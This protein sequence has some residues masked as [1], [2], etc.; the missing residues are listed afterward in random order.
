MADV[1][2][3]L[4]L[5]CA[6]GAGW[7]L[8]RQSQRK[9]DSEP[10]PASYYKGLNYLL[11]ETP[12]T[13]LDDFIESL[14]VNVQTLETHLA[15]GNL[16]R[17][18]GEVERA[19]KIH[20]NLLARPSLPPQH[21]HQAHLELARDFIS[22]G[23]LDRA[24]RL[25]EG[26]LEEAPEL[27]RLALRYLMEIYQDEKEWDRAIRIATQLLPRKSLLKPVTVDRSIPVALSHFSCER[28]VRAIRGNDFH[29]ARNHLR[30]ALQYD[31]DCIRATLLSGEIEMHT[32]H[33]AQGARILRK[34]LLQNPDYIPE[35]LIPLKHCYQQMGKLDGWQQFLEQAL[36]LKPSTRVMLEL[37][38]AIRLRQ[39]EEQERAFLEN[40]LRER[41][42]LRGV[43]ELV[44]IRM[45]ADPADAN[46]AALQR[47]IT[48]LLDDKPSYLCSSC[49]F[50]GQR[51]HWLCP[52]CKEWGVMK[53]IRGPE[54]D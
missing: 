54:G 22:A 13:A 52:S 16:M 10:F 4:L 21:L 11:N 14:E 40:H 28:A 44:R 18:K 33:Y 50:S 35:A 34:I 8:G 23:L 51:L 49:G 45:A 15:V 19:I 41:P 39:G 5:F 7:F 12:D 27:R 42:S 48:Q 26:L 29:T 9:L 20:Q 43:A 47:L 32:G 24:E 37:A 6:T 17:R 25:L 38:E 31:K 30:Q 3:F 46:L 1:W 53:P 2:L 36:A